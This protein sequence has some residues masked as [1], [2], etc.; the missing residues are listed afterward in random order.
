MFAD[1]LYKKGFDAL[2]TR[3]A[4]DPELPDDLLGFRRTGAPAL[5]WPE[6]I[7]PGPISHATGPDLLLTVEPLLFH[8]SDSNETI[9]QAVHTEHV[10]RVTVS[11]NL[12]GDYIVEEACVYLC[13]IVEEI[14]KSLERWRF[15]NDLGPSVSIELGDWTQVAD[16]I[17]T[18]EV[19]IT[20]QKY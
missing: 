16:G 17:A 13:Y 10:F 20:E 18:L 11:L 6:C 19:Y 9:A 15:T 12:N 7:K 3:L 1:S 5:T 8:K 14:T 2:M 4:T